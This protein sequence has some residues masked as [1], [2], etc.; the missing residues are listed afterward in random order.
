M[1]RYPLWK[2]LIVLAVLLLGII[3]ALPNLYGEDRRCR[4]RT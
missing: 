4:S 1:N 2:N 3:Y